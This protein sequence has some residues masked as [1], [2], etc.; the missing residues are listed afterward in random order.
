ML[1]D[2]D[3]PPG[4][5][6]N[7]I[8]VIRLPN[9]RWETSEGL[10][11]QGWCVEASTHVLE[12]GADVDIECESQCLTKAFDPKQLVTCREVCQPCPIEDQERYHDEAIPCL[13]GEC[14]ADTITADPDY[15]LLVGGEPVDPVA[16]ITALETAEPGLTII[17]S[18][19][20]ANYA[21]GLLC[22]DDRPLLTTASGTAIASFPDF[23]ITGD[24]Q[25]TLFA[26]RNPRLILG[27]INTVE[28]PAHRRNCTCVVT[29]QTAAF[30]Y[31]PCAGPYGVEMK[32]CGACC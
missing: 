26:V 17:G 31:E 5:Q 13:I 23:P 3:N 1:I 16:A 21:S 8:P 10:F 32:F 18:S 12:C 15:D 19:A 2:L 9:G 11:T 24:G 25:T 28:G 6:W 29:V 20:L 4:E 30:V 14:I 22:C 27:P 7:G